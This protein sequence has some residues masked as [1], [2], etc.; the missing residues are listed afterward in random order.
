MTIDLI[1]EKLIEKIKSLQEG[2]EVPSVR[3]LVKEVFNFKESTNQNDGNGYTYIY[4]DFELK[5]GDFFE[6]YE[7]LMDKIEKEDIILDFS[8]WDDQIVGLPYNLS[9]VIR[10][11]NDQSSK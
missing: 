11:N 7:K 6:I 3:A 8:K 5:E 9:F 4:E 2:A 1:V 10:R